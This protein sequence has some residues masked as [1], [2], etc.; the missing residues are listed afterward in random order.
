MNEIRLSSPTTAVH[1]K[2]LDLWQQSLRVGQVL[3]MTV[4]DKLPSGVLMLRS[5]AHQVTAMSDV[6]VRQGAVL[7]LEV[8]T[9]SPVPS[10]RIITAPAP[11]PTGASVPVDPVDGYLKLLVPSQGRVVAPL[12]TLLDPVQN[13]NIL[14][15]LGMQRDELNRMY[16]MLNHRELLANPGSLKRAV[17]Q[18]GLFL[19]SQLLSSWNSRGALPPGDLKAALLRLLGRVNRVLRRSP[20]AEGAGSNLDILR[21]LQSELEGAL[22]TITLKQ[23]AAGQVDGGSSG[24]W[25]FDIPLWF[26][27]TV[28]GVSLCIER[29]DAAPEEDPDQQDWKILLSISLPQLGDVEAELFVRG[30]KVS[31]VIVAEHDETARLVKGSL[32]QLKSGLESQGLNVSVLRCHQASRDE[33]NSGGLWRKVVDEDV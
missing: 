2:N 10:L 16:K 15:L 23:L 32:P 19:E 17:Q 13:A 29:K 3:R 31:V 6:P 8:S 9:L 1:Q 25:S 20:Q 5:G 11:A 24:A 22:A 33:A 26:H 27:N 4:V 28:Y 14:S 18:S 12:L 30:S 7:T 21:N